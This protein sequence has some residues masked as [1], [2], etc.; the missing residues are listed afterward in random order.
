M[1]RK[2][3]PQTREM[4]KTTRAAEK[5]AAA[6]IKLRKQPNLTARAGKPRTIRMPLEEWIA[7][8]D[9]PVQRDTKRHWETKAHKYLKNLKSAHYTVHMAV[10][11]TGKRY[12]L[13]AHARTYGW[14]NGLTDAVPDYVTVIVHY[15]N[16][17]DDVI[18]E[19]NTFDSTGQA[20]DAAD[21]LFSAFKQFNIVYQSKFF[22]NCRGIVTAMKEALWEIGKLYEVPDAPAN[23]RNVSVGTC[24]QFFQHQLRALDSIDPPYSKFKGPPTTAFLLAHFKYTELGKHADDVIEFFRLYR[25]DAGVK[26][27]KIHDAVYEVTRIMNR[28]SGGGANQRLARL[29]QLLG[30]V[31]R[32][33]SPGGKHVNWQNGQSVDMDIYLLE[34]SALKCKNIQRN[35]RITR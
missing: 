26:N 14:V 25:N 19:Y 21:Q 13:D 30:C 6:Q 31:E 16:D 32:F 24:V 4:T 35:K 10:T 8:A 12:K 23:L 18:D 7:V 2:E 3:H 17:E 28:T 22:H 11:D 5:I 34:E 9:A 15:V 33:V 27:G 29:A 20:K 1:A